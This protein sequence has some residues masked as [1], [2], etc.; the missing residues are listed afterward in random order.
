MLEILGRL[1]PPNG[2]MRGLIS[3]IVILAVAYLMVTRQADAEALAIA[4]VVMASYGIVQGAQALT[5]RN[6]Y[7]TASPS[8]PLTSEADLAAAKENERIWRESTRVDLELKKIELS[9]KQEAL[10]GKRLASNAKLL[11]EFRADMPPT[12]LPVAD[13]AGALKERDDVASDLAA[14]ASGSVFGG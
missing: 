3:L 13:G 9:E 12:G 5:N 2:K 8:V 10:R 1:I 6:R 14:P 4:G 11:A 7:D